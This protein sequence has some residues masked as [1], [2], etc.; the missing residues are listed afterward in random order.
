MDSPGR[1]SLEFSWGTSSTQLFLSLQP[2][3]ILDAVERLGFR[4]TGRCLALNSMENR[5]FEVEIEIRG[6]PRSPSECFRIV[7]FY[8]PGRWTDGQIREEHGFLDALRQDDIPA[9]CAESDSHGK[10]L[11]QLPGLDIYY[12]VFPKIGG[13]NPDE[14][15]LDACERLG[16]LLARVH[17]TGSRL[18]I[19]QRLHLDP[20][21]YGHNSIDFLLDSES[22]PLELED[23]LADTAE[24][25]CEVAA[26]WF[27]EAHAQPVH[28]D[29]HLGNVLW[30]D[31]GAF[32]VDFDDCVIAPPVQDIWLLAPGRDADSLAKR[33][34]LLEAYEAMR[35]FDRGS[36]RLVEPLRALRYLH[37]AA[38][39]A[40]RWPDPA[41]PRA[42]P[43]FGTRTYWKE[44]HEDLRECLELMRA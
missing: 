27:E 17:A 39:V 13:R 32:L 35:E 26:P 18:P 33:E 23:A 29:C 41:F 12:A 8:R 38:W 4:C 31:R 14:L 19:R 6:E 1:S 25:I 10:T 42:F 40:K 36:L 28:G 2:D 44:L 16:R 15:G 5:V 24:A 20:V 22:I 11:H 7:K 30:N 9:V 34:A 21:T 3:A 43:H 37:F